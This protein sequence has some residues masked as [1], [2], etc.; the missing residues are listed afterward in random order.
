MTSASNVQEQYSQLVDRID[1][2]SSILGRLVIGNPGLCI[3]EDDS[4]ALQA[5]ISPDTSLASSSSSNSADYGG[6]RRRIDATAPSGEKNLFA[7]LISF[8][9]S[10]LSLSLCDALT[11]SFSFAR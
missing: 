10:S 8:S 7:E 1:G 4:R 9:F 6:K 3:T 5:L 11:L 2:L